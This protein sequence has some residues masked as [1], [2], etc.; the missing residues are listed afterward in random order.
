ML[1]SL[2]KIS[3]K[4]NKGIDISEIEKCVTQVLKVKTQMK[5][6]GLQEF[7]CNFLNIRKLKTKNFNL[8]HQIIGSPK[9]VKIFSMRKTEKFVKNTMR[10]LDDSYFFLNLHL[11]KLIWHNYFQPIRH[12]ILI[13]KPWNL[14]ITE[15]TVKIKRSS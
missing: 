10:F 15:I 6:K 2:W 4:V 13:Q 14:Q 1:K 5:L 3:I 8:L 9:V 12:K 7:Y 11:N